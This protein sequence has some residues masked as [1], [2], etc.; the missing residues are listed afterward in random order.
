MTL[1]E[2]CTFHWR[3]LGITDTESLKKSISEGYLFRSVL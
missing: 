3:M 2:K 1:K